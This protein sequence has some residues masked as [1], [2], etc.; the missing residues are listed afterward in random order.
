MITEDDLQALVEAVRIAQ[1]AFV[2]G[3]F[4]PLFDVSE[5]TIFPPMGGGAIG[6]PGFTE[7]SAGFAA[8]FHDGEAE[9]D[10]VQTIVAGD[11]VCVVQVERNIVR[12]GDGTDRVPWNLRATMVFRR[13]ESKPAGWTM[14]HRHADP[15]VNHLG[16]DGSRA[17]MA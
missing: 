8:Q 7:L 5:G 1:V 4:D 14:L 6:G 15:C 17:L 16:F 9:I 12:F 11:V 3:R 13:D 2:N 10:V